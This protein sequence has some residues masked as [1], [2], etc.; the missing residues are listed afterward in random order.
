MKKFILLILI[1]F[2]AS[3]G[4]SKPQVHENTYKSTTT[5]EVLKDTTVAIA[6]DKSQA[7]YEFKIVNDTIRII[8]TIV[9]N[10]GNYLEAPTI[11]IKDNKLIVGAQA[12]IHKQKIQVKEVYR[13]DTLIQTQTIHSVTNELNGWQNFNYWT[14][15]I[16][17]GLVALAVI[18]YII[19]F[20][21]RKKGII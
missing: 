21:L 9:T 6:G 20:I 11:L 4:V 16:F 3:C 1:C 10:K 18:V 13:L 8:D 14:G 7:I 15:M 17:W 12:P 2:L 5:K 19:L